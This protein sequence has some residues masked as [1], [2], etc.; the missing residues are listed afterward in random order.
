MRSFPA[1]KTQCVMLWLHI[2]GDTHRGRTCAVEYTAMAGSVSN[3]P[4]NDTESR[5]RMV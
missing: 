4:K 1:E 2:M 3:M 5:T